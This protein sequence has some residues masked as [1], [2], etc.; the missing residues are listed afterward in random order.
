M[1]FGGLECNNENQTVQRRPNKAF[2]VPD[3][4]DSPHRTFIPSQLTTAT[5]LC[6][7]ASV[8]IYNRPSHL[9]LRAITQR[10]AAMLICSCRFM[11][12]GTDWTAN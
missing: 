5:V 12:R 7:L 1:R 4:G 6:L 2:A 3:H 10:D 9:V 11:V 8:A